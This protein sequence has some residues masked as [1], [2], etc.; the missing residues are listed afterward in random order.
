MDL[1]EKYIMTRLYNLVF[2]PST[3][4]DEEKDL[5]MQTRIRSL[6]WINTHLL[7]T[8]MNE[9][10]SPEV[11]NQVENAITGNFIYLFGRNLF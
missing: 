3:T 10:Q 4:D 1:L 8:P 7:D 2:C 6:H 5:A 9:A 11:S